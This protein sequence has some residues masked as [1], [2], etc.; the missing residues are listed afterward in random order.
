M[1][2]LMLSK[3]QKNRLTEKANQFIDEMFKGLEHGDDDHRKWLKDKMTTYV[4]TLSNILVDVSNELI[5]GFE[6]CI[7]SVLDDEEEEEIKNEKHATPGD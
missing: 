7:D 6:N 2:L 3:D 4:D 1:R 5:K